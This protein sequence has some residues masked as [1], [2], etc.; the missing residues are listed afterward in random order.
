MWHRGRSRERGGEQ[1]GRG[2]RKKAMGE[3]ASAGCAPPKDRPGLAQLLDS[4]PAV[5]LRWG[6][7]ERR[8]VKERR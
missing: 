8:G 7:R 4:R 6:E 3:V 2:R 5:V 1:G